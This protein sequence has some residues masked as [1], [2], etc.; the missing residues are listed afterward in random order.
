MCQRLQGY[1]VIYG[2][3]S[4]S[5][6]KLGHFIACVNGILIDDSYK[7]YNG[8]VRSE[9]LNEINLKSIFFG[10]NTLLIVYELIK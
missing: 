10:E 3:D 9:Q 7:S 5:K 2:Y 6:I 4:S 8:L 1:F